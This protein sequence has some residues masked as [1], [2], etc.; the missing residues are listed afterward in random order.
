MAVEPTL[1]T[2]VVSAP[3]K[4]PTTSGGTS[5]TSSTSSA[6]LASNF[7][8]FL[9][10]LTTQLQNQ[11]PL[12]P[13]DTNQFTQQLVQF[14]Q[15]EQQLKQN[16]QLASLIA[17]QK[18]AQATQALNFVGSKV[19]FD[20]SNSALKDGLATWSLTS[21]KNVSATVNIINSTGQTVYSSTYNIN[22]GTHNFVW[23]GK[24]ND[25]SQWPPGNYKLSIVAKDAAG[26]T[27]AVDTDAVGVV[28]SV[29][30]T[31]APP[32]LTIGNQTFT[33]DQI[34]RVIRAGSS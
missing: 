15:V 2:T 6:T 21:P 22:A 13:L 23:D 32:L 29:D 33:V 12:D 4:P 1:P 17:L 25:G 14:A 16:D 28:D 20:G 3:A 11:N 34:K 7:Q 24:G 18:T 31:A 26:E 30:L 19:V 9:T 5:T 27:T 10:L 8:T